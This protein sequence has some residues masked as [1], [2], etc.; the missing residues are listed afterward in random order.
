MSLD[1]KGEK[2]LMNTHI[3][4]STEIF[5]SNFENKFRLFGVFL[6]SLKWKNSGMIIRNYKDGINVKS[7]NLKFSWKSV[8]KVS[9]KLLLKKTNYFFSNVSHAY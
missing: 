4:S 8:W 2:G 1:G 9:A 3:T 7:D 6:C 5:T